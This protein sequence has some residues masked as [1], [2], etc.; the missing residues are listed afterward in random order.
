VP[1]VQQLSQVECGAACLAM[2]LGYHGRK[3]TVSEVRKVMGVARDGATA[4]MILEGARYFD[5]RAKA[6]KLE[7][8]AEFKFV[9]LPAIVHWDFS[10]FVVVER[11]SPKTVEIADPGTGRQ[12]ISAREFDERFTGVVLTLAPGLDFQ[13]RRTLGQ[14]M[15][16]SYLGQLLKL[17]GVRGLLAQIVAASLFLQLAGLAVPILTQVFVDQVLPYRITSVM[18]MMGLGMLVLVLAK[19]VTGYLRAALLIYVQGRT[20][21]Q[22]MVGFFH[23]LLSLPFRYFQ[24]RN[25]GDLLMRLSSNEAIREIITSQSVSAVLDG[26]FVLSYLLILLVT[27]P[28][29]ALLVIAVGTMQIGLMLGTG[30]PVRALMERDLVTQAASQDYLVE[31]LTGIGTVK[32]AGAEERAVE[33]WSNL[34]FAN[35]NVSL[36]RSQ[37][38]AMIDTAMTTL[39]TLSPLLLL[40]VGAYQVLNGSMSL[41]TM[42]A[43]NALG[44]AFL[45]PLSSLVTTGQQFQL[46]GAHLE[47]I[48]DVLDAAPEQDPLTVQ[49]VPALTGRIELKDVS[50][51]YAPDAPLVL[52]HVSLAIEPG[53]KIALVGRTGSGKSTLALLLLG[54]YPPTEGEIYYDE[55]PLS[56]LDYRTVRRQFGVVMQDAFLF[57]GSIRQNIAFNDPSMPMEQVIEAARLAGVLEEIARMPMAFETHVGEGGMGLSGGQRQRISIAR[58]VAHHP[59]L[60]I[61]DE[62]T[63]H[64][65]AVTEETVDQSLSQLRCTRLVIA[66]RL[67]TVRNADRIL[68]LDAGEIAESGTHEALLALNGHYAELVRSQQGR[69]N[70]RS[71]GRTQDIES[72]RLTAADG[73][74]C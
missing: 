27:A 53:E 58:A 13:K 34:F 69:G 26:L 32:A 65:D 41:G 55:M 37:L 46:V 70:D 43:L 1:F 18:T 57:S 16:R 19:M 59:S 28:L 17:P 24:E 66:H 38:S 72:S 25:T 2:V 20:D 44:L 15:W 7:N 23:H 64:L 50:F 3:T 33:H 4:R 10:H 47:R 30:R 49:P 68:V 5:M 22:M 45:S 39:R 6:F 51:R 9:P 35:L 31:A 11:W 8:P 40:W 67:S 73:D 60:L 21:A 63:S 48:G 52:S 74:H 54:L 36:R 42:L 12:R 29:Y 62:A 61:L 56:C 14:P 71:T